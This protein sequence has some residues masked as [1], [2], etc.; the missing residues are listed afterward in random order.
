M[1]IWP[2]AVEGPP[3]EAV[4]AAVLRAN[5]H[6][7][8][9]VHGRCGKHHLD[10]N[11][12]RYTSAAKHAPWLIVRDLDQ[13]ATCAAELLRAKQPGG[14][15]G[16]V[17]IAVRAIE[18]W[19]LADPASAR[20]LGVASS[21]LPSKVEDLD[22]PKATLIQLARRSRRTGIRE[23]IVPTLSRSIGPGYVDQIR[24]FCATT[25]TPAVAARR[26]DSL[27]R[28]IRHIQKRRS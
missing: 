27:A 21:A 3:D 15:P 25:W 8:G 18:A 17:R 5:G 12:R 4:I 9:A 16:C 22:D 2:L 1:A 10:D 14:H 23:D 11:L 28:L 20:W 7:V 19:L 24:T 13:D 6:D 26:S